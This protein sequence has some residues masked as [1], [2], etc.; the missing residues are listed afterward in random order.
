MA[1]SGELVP[2]LKPLRASDVLAE[3]SVVFGTQ[4]VAHERSLEPHVADDVAVT[5]DP[6]LLLRV[7][8]NM[9]RNAFEATEPGG[10]VSVACNRVVREG[11]RGETNG[12]EG[13]ARFTVRNEGVIPPMVQE[14]IFQRSFST[15]SQYGRGLGT[16]SMKLLGERYLGG[17]VSFVS[18]AECGTVFSIELPPGSTSPG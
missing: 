2:D 5:S 7:L 12:H 8:V 18:N 13:G 4:G 6:A 10:K 3:L 11:A 1:E 16:Y 17:K 9:V 15:K 14:H